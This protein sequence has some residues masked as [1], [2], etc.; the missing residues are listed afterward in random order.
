MHTFPYFVLCRIEHY[1]A[2]RA[3]INEL[4]LF[5]R[6]CT[7]QDHNYTITLFVHTQ[8]K[9]TAANQ[10]HVVVSPTL[11][12]PYQLGPIVLTLTS[13]RRFKPE[14]VKPVATYLTEGMSSI[15][16]VYTPRN[17]VTEKSFLNDFMSSNCPRERHRYLLKRAIGVIK[18]SSAKSLP[19]DWTNVAVLSRRVL[20]QVV[21]T[22]VQIS[23]FQGLPD[24]INFIAVFLA[25]QFL[26]SPTKVTVGR[27][28]VLHVDSLNSAS[29]MIYTRLVNAVGGSA[30]R[31]CSYS[32]QC[33]QE[34]ATIALT[35]SRLA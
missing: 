20:R 3:V 35:R 18:T 31:P 32:M 30:A 23:C 33:H 17:H 15:T 13:S 26:T 22:D 6:V 27:V 16:P 28:T 10:V 29:L 12:L 19:Q 1:K 24:T 25:A 5:Y 7:V 8:K 34:E 21:I 4:N 11:T 14:P 2:S 9:K